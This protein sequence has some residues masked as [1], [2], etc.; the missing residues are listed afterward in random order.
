MASNAIDSVH[1]L[2]KVIETGDPVLAAEV[3]GAD[4]HNR[5]AVNSP[6]SCAIPGPAGVLASSAWMRSAFT[7]LRFPVLDTGVDDQRGQVFVRVHMQGRHTG[8]FVLFRDEKLDKII[9]PSGRELD[10]EQIHLLTVRGGKVIRHEAVRD[11]MTM[12]GQLGAFPPT[13][14]MAARLAIWKLTGRDRRAADAVSASAAEA[15]KSV[16]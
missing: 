11:D 10:Y 5:E 13:P 9:P 8:P 3:V 2:F 4:F 12:L 1:S 15:A 16:G 6:V 7:G 14:A